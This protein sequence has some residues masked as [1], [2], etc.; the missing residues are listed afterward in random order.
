MENDQLTD[1]NKQLDKNY[2]QLNNQ[3]MIYQTKVIIFFYKKSNFQKIKFYK[4]F[5][6]LDGLNPRRNQTALNSQ[7]LL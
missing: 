4:F 1:T 2:E 7:I 5:K 6:N 3:L